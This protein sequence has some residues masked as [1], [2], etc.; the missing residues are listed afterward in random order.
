MA[1]RSSRAASQQSRQRLRDIEAMHQRMVQSLI[2]ER[3]EARQ[4]AD[5][6]QK[7]IKRLRALL[8]QPLAPPTPRPSAPVSPVVKQPVQPGERQSVI[9]LNALRCGGAGE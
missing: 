2:D 9:V 1:R 4:D 8:R 6:Q 7:E 3:D 5:R